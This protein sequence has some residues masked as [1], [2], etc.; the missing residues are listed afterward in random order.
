MFI[1]FTIFLF[2]RKQVAC[3]A[4]GDCVYAIGGSDIYAVSGS[5][6]AGRYQTVERYSPVTDQWVMVAPLLSPRSGA[7]AAV[8]DGILY[9]CGGFDGHQYLN[10]VEK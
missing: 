4:M 7:G 2:Y 1:L 9:V 8:L 3:A 6:H 10:T 5:D